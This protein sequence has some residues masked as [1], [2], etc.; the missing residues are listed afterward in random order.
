MSEKLRVGVVLP[1]YRRL[2]SAENIRR[3]AELS[4]TLGFDSV[5]VTDHVVVPAGSVDAFGPT[6]FE[7]VT[8]MA[9]VA[10]ITTR[11]SIG[12]AILIIPY[13]H[14]LLL[15]KMLA[16]ADQLSGGRLIVGAG[17]GWLEA[18]SELMGVAHRKR[19]RIADEALAVMRSCWEDEKPAL[20]GETDGLSGFHFAPRP[21]AG[22]R[23]PVLIGGASVAALRRAA[24][25]GD[26][27]IG[28]GLTFEELEAS[29]A[30][31][32]KELAAA[33][34]RIEDV[35]IAM[36]TGLQV[37]ERAEEVTGSPSEMGWKTGDFKSGGNDRTP[38]RGLR[39]QVVGDFRRAAELGVDH[40][41]FEFP[42]SRGEESMELFETLAELRAAAGV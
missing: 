39:E 15:A 24:R 2:A 12:A 34:R 8:T 31:F 1:T 36:R 28:D 9:Y 21:Y 35:E 23:L 10:G 32:R 11:V 18:E 6:F 33:D 38:F 30:Q 16:T 14:P 20:S 29:L 25:L 22:R 41:V 37:V 3:A 27:W 4:E 13:R 42:V 40:L 19:G 26:G 7:G 17:L 5:W